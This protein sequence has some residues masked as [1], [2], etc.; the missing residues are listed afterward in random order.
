MTKMKILGKKF[1]PQCDSENVDMVAGGVTGSWICVDCGYVG[2]FP[3][4]PHEDDDEENLLIQEDLE[5]IKESMKNTTK[6]KT[7]NK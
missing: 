6:S 3:E 2:A 7:R 1:C 4:K 5:E